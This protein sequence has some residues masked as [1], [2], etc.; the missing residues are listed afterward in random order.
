MKNEQFTIR[1]ESEYYN[2]VYARWMP[3]PYFWV[4]QDVRL[5]SDRIIISPDEH[6]SR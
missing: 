5:F 6:K 4:G 3:V 2:E 1:P